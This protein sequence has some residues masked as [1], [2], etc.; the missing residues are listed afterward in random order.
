MKTVETVQA[1]EATVNTPL[2]Q[3]VN[4]REWIRLKEV[5]RLTGWSLKYVR[6]LEDN[7]VLDTRQDFPKAKRWYRRS[8]IEKLME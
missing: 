8:Q 2:K 3:G 5:L 1:T 4:E 6:K 7:Q